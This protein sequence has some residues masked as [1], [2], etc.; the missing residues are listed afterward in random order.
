MY[1]TLEVGVD[2]LVLELAGDFAD[3]TLQDVIDVAQQRSVEEG[4]DFI[5]EFVA[6]FENR[7]PNAMLSRYYRSDSENITRRST[8]EEVE[9]VSSRT[10]QQ[11][12]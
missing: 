10:G 3:E 7:D 5:T 11:C 2:Q 6:E 1:V 8:N 9:E 12:G 4:T